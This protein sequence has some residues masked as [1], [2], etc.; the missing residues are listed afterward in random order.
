VHT[1]ESDDPFE[2]DRA[3]ARANLRRHGLRFADAVGVFEDERACTRPDVATALDERRF[4]SLGR[5]RT[6]R[7]VVVGYAKRGRRIHILWMRPA[8]PAE[9]RRYLESDR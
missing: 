5:D 8:T 9:R 7:T 3:R 1:I 6:G 2:W 4:V